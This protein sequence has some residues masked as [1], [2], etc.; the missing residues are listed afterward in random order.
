MLLIVAAPAGRRA[1]RLRP[2]RASRSARWGGA[3]A[4]RRAYP[5]GGGAAG[6]AAARAGNRRRYAALIAGAWRSATC[7]SDGDA[8]GALVQFWAPATQTRSPRSTGTAIYGETVGAGAPR[9]RPTRARGGA[10]AGPR[11][12]SCART[13]VDSLSAAAHARVCPGGLGTRAVAVGVGG[14]TGP[15]LMGPVGLGVR[16]LPPPR[17]A[18]S[19]GAARPRP[20]RAGAD[21]S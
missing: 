20:S 5:V 2:P 21:R 13:P 17:A 3:V 10:G 4:A 9:R 12:A 11:T 18:C 6:G 15:T 16:G 1:V 7:D 19:R 14:S 8:Q